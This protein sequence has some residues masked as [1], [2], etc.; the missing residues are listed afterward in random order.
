MPVV[1]VDAEGAELADPRM[2]RISHLAWQILA[3]WMLMEKSSAKAELAAKRVSLRT[4]LLWRL[5]T[6]DLQVAEAE[7]GLDGA[8]TVDFDS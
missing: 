7:R 6:L 2:A 4:R 5:A 3:I 1:A 8:E